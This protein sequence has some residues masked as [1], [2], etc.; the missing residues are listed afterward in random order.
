L[1][2]L[3]L[4]Y[5]FNFNNIGAIITPLIYSLK[6]N[7]FE[8]IQL[9]CTSFKSYSNLRHTMCI[10]IEMMLMEQP[11]MMLMEPELMEQFEMTEQ[12]E[13]EW[14]LYDVPGH[15]RTYEM[16]LEAVR[17]HPGHLRWVPTEMI[18]DVIC[19]TALEPSEHRVDVIQLLVPLDAS[20]GY[21]HAPIKLMWEL[22]R[23]LR[24]VM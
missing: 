17:A 10:D 5:I 9:N 6:L 24:P 15:E 11:E 23:I 20:G 16:C 4:I 14:C 1:K 7:F 2:L 19:R 18:D 13:N 21:S 22:K 8:K 3:I 12:S